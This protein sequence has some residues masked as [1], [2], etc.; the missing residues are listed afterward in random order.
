VRDDMSFA[1]WALQAL[2]AGK[3]AGLQLEGLDECIKK[4]IN[5]MQ[6]R[7]FKDGGFNYTAGGNPTGLTATG[8]FAMQQF[9]YGNEPEVR[10]A[11]DFMRE[12]NPAFDKAGLTGKSVG[13]CPQYYCYYATQCKYLAANVPFAAGK[14]VQT[15]EK[16]NSAMKQAYPSSIREA[17][18]V[19]D[20][21][22]V[23]HDSG[24]FS[25]LDAHSSRPVMDT[26]L[27]A[28]QLMVYYRYVPFELGG[29]SYDSARIAGMTFADQVRK[30]K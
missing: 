2:K 13:S 29:Q 4:A 25:N 14:D 8:C 11:L 22:G 17:N 6:A 5:C 27:V 18:S 7:N 12:W 24:Y 21:D 26:C 20:L 15:W 9:G 1:G 28:L 23:A 3:M 10:S 19:V 16:W 30:F